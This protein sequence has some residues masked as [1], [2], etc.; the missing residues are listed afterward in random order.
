MIIGIC[1]DQEIYRDEII[2]HCKNMLK[3]ET[4]TYECFASGEELLASGLVCDFLFLDI[5][6]D[7]IDGIRVKEILESGTFSTRIIFLTSHDERMIE[8]FGANVIGFLKKPVR[9]E[10]LTPIIKKIEQFMERNTIEWEESGQEYAIAVEDIL[11]IEAQDKYTCVICRNEKHLVRRTVKNWEELLPDTDFCRVNRSYLINMELFD[12]TKNEIVLE[13]G[14]SVRLS[15]KN[16]L[17]IEEQYK[18][19]LRKRMNEL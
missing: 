5:E 18:K 3:Q 15:R 11:Y 2:C 1:D 7:G 4:V 13:T 16:K 14:K 10:C 9:V 19:Y 8:A 17:L 12:R 6:L